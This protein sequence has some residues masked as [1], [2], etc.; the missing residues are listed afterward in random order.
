MA[1]KKLLDLHPATLVLVS[2]VAVIG[3]GTV[4]LCLPFALRDQPISLIDA[5]FT[6]TS[7]VCVTGLAVVDTATRFSTMGQFVLL[8]LIQVGG[9]GVMTIAVFLFQ[10][11]GRTIPF[12]QRM[13]VQELFAHTPR[14]DILRLIRNVIGF[15][16]ASELLGAALLTIHWW[17]TEPLGRALWLAVFHAVSAFC[18]AGFAL[19]SDNLV[20][21]SDSGLLNFTICTL[22]VVGGIGFPVLYDL[23]LRLQS[24]HGRRRLSLQTRTVLL[25]TMILIVGG[26][27]LFG[28][29]E[30]S[31]VEADGTFLQIVLTSVFQSITCRTAGFNTVDIA[32]LREA[33]LFVM[34]FL[35][36]VGASPGSCGGGVK[37]T[38][39]AV[40]VNFTISRVRRQRRVNM[41]KKS[42][43]TDTISRSILV[44]LAAAVIIGLILFLLLAGDVAAGREIGG[45]HGAMLTYLFE[46]VSA[47]ATVGL[48]MGVTPALTVW[49]KLLVVVAMLIGRVGLLTFAYLVVGVGPLRGLEYSEENL[50]V[51]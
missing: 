10:G 17:G 40:L 50:M 46:V 28:L 45:R 6:A 9:L 39:L 42:I 26:A 41:F 1:N 23:R 35:M 38:T 44:V 11:L 34:I 16:L 3:V 21:Y 37:T 51:G 15:T 29:L 2:F 22:I 13:A 27:L 5:L 25:T 30:W 14:A 8:G 19:F 31:A 36:F 32:A 33:T 24:R 4:L 43:P 20:D 49:S 7:A 12:R 48:S 47:F 18:N